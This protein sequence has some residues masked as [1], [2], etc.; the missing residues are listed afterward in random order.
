M[1]AVML[2]A[3]FQLTFKEPA[4][5][6][7]STQSTRQPKP[8]FPC[9]CLEEECGFHFLATILQRVSAVR[10]RSRRGHWISHPEPKDVFF[11]SYCLCDTSWR[12]AA[13][14]WFYS[15]GLTNS[16]KGK[17]QLL[18]FSGC[19][20][21]TSELLTCLMIE[22]VQPPTW[23]HSI[24][25]FF[26]FFVFLS[27]G[28]LW[29]TWVPVEKRRFTAGVWFCKN[30]TF[31]HPHWLMQKPTLVVL[32]KTQPFLWSADGIFENDFRLLIFVN[33]KTP[34]DQFRR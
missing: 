24:I 32:I 31:F 19:S 9:S 21:N 18:L 29:A 1:M 6:F 5:E 34:L 23:I 17:S 14:F 11:I 15:S 33:T 20:F 7:Q 26:F 22:D 2:Q 3:C 4:Q 27:S 13:T 12:P 25:I 16:V 28:R 10:F 8:P 30:F